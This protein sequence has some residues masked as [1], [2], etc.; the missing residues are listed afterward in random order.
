MRS[1][2]VS[3]PQSS[4][5]PA[6]TCLSVCLSSSQHPAGPGS[7]VSFPETLGL[8]KSLMNSLLRRF[9]KGSFLEYQKYCT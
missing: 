5:P 3:S 6:S 9:D 7:S 2:G 8:S 4:V 1:Q